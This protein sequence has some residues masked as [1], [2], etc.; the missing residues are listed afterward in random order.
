MRPDLIATRERLLA[1]QTQATA[2][3]AESIRIAR[4]PASAHAWLR[5]SFEAAQAAA[6]DPALASRPLAGLAISVKDLFDIAGQPTPAG[7]RVLADAPPAAADSAAVA[8]LTASGGGGY[9]PPS[10][11]GMAM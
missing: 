2:E 9:G 11:Y 3:M 10:I 5:T 6:A 4:S 7:S 1:R 8:R